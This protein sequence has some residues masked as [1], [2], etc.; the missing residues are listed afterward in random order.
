MNILKTLRDGVHAG[1]PDDPSDDASST[2]AGSQALTARYARL[3]E[4]QAI[5]SLTERT[6]VE[7]AAIEE[8]ER[9]NRDRDPVLSKLRYLRQPEPLPGYDALEPDAITAALSGAELGTI[10]ATREYERKLRGRPL[11]LAEIANAVH[12]AGA[13]PAAA[14]DAV[15]AYE[16]PRR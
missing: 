14:S 12:R 7:L 2:D 5:G 10:K 16:Q 1:S 4:R 3:G 8:F 6:Q 15:G 9:A 13:Q 11:V